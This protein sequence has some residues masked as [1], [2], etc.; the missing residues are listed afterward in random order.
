LRIRFKVTNSFLHERSRVSSTEFAPLAHGG[1]MQHQ[2]PRIG[3][4]GS[5]GG[6]NMGDEAILQCIIEQLRR[7]VNADIVVF[8][9]DAEDTM[10]RH[11]VDGVV[12]VRDLSRDEIKPEIRKLDLFI[13]GGGG[14]L[15]DAD[16][17]AY[18][19]EVFM[20]YES[21]VPVMVY[22]ISAGPL[23][24]SAIQAKV[25]DALNHAAAITVRDRL[26]MQVLEQAGVRRKIMLTADP[27]LL[28]GP[29]GDT[30]ATQRIEALRSK[31]RVVG[32]SVRERG[33]A[34]PDIDEAHYHGLLADT[35]DFIIDRFGASVL[36]IPMERKGFDLQHSHSVMARMLLPQKAT[37]L[38]E[39]YTPANLLSIMSM[40]DMAVGMR[41]HFLIFALL[42]RIPF[43]GLP[44]SSKVRSFLAELN[45][46]LPPLNLI[47]SGRLNAYIDQAW[48]N[49]D[50]ILAK[51]QAMLPELKKRA[52]MNNEIAVKVLKGEKF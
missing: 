17:A 6:L 26:A 7:S 50:G 45:V 33:V 14:I 9:R 19:R 25:S 46:V 27:A 3:I 34:A 15:Y 18:L 23:N 38:E 20:A 42:Q 1:F 52:M 30:M 36:F 5:Y 48:D 29:D 35:A 28:L 8:S 37:V 47:D 13:L 51:T 11:K 49:R 2:R 31:G 32:I 16:A 41:L 40:L 21:K 44:Y 12:P 24:D 10:R 4:S 43:V 39:E 22:A